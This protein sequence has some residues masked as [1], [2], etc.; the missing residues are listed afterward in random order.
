MSR[1]RHFTRITVW[2]VCF[3]CIPP[4]LYASPPNL[5]LLRQ[6]VQ[7]Y[8]DSGAYHREVKAIIDKANHYI[9]QRVHENNRRK[10]PQKLALVLD[11]DETI[12]S[13][14]KYMKE[15][16]F[17]ATQ[18]QLRKEILAAN[19]P[20]ITPTLLLYKKAQK[21]GVAVF[22]ITG[23]R[24]NQLPETIKNLKREGI[25]HWV[26]LYMKPQHYNQDSAIPYKSS[27]RK[28]ISNN[29][30]TIIASIG[31]QCSDLVG[32]YTEKAFKLPNP[33]YYLP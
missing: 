7:N 31:D 26:G 20:A 32:G 18:K 12:L 3:L 13:N 25:T 27:I 1:A 19:D 28:K 17:V 29:G 30:Y 9:A 23:R 14:Y 4:L 10:I 16:Q 15:R 24:S 11:I 22:F 5:G 8:H 33:F 2:L 6:Q 21:L